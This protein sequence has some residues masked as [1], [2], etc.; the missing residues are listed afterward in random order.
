MLMTLNVHVSHSGRKVRSER[1]AI[2]AAAAAAAAE[3][4]TASTGP[5]GQGPSSAGGNTGLATGQS[6]AS[7]LLDLADPVSRDSTV[8]RDGNRPAITAV[9]ALEATGW[10]SASGSHHHQ[11]QHHN[12]DTI[13]HARAATYYQDTRYTSHHIRDPSRQQQHQQQQHYPLP[14]PAYPRSHYNHQQPVTGEH[15]FPRD[16]GGSGGGHASTS[17]VRIDDTPSSINDDHRSLASQGGHP[18]EGVQCASSAGQQHSGSP[19]AKLPESTNQFF[20]A[21]RP[22]I[23]AFYPLARPGIASELSPPTG[24][25]TTSSTGEEYLRMTPATYKS[26]S[27]QGGTA[28][29]G[30]KPSKYSRTKTN[31]NLA[32]LKQSESGNDAEF[33]PTFAVSVHAVIIPRSPEFLCLLTDM[34]HKSTPAPNRHS[35]SLIR[36]S[37]CFESCTGLHAHL[38]QPQRGQHRGGLCLRRE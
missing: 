30:D 10:T 15:F 14:S 19:T 4:A 3:A 37:V 9:Q 18:Y 32:T 21:E 38:Q 11:Q 17:R 2:A 33:P 25:A 7:A 12:G 24:A 6:N 36:T 8:S 16:F 1:E 29:P 35:R 31:P 34:G 5:G 13:A 27:G 26:P 23:S 28:G 20:E 22:D